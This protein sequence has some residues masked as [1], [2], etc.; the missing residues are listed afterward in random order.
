MPTGITGNSASLRQSFHN[1]RVPPGFRLDFNLPR[2]KASHQPRS[3]SWPTSSPLP[4][5]RSYLRR[6]A[7]LLLNL[8]ILLQ[9]SSFHDISKH[10]LH[11]LWHNIPRAAAF[12]CHSPMPIQERDLACRSELKDVQNFERD[13]YEGK[14]LDAR[15]WMEAPEKR[16]PSPSGTPA[17]AQPPAYRPNVPINPP[18]YKPKDPMPAPKYPGKP[19]KV[20]QPKLPTIHERR[21]PSPSG[22]PAA[23]QPP[24]YRPNV[25]I[26]PPPYK[27]KD[28]MPAPKYP[29]KPSKVVQPKLPTIH[30]RRSPSPSGTPAAA[31]PPAYRPN[32]PINPP[33]YKPKDPMPAPKYPGKPSKVVQPKLPTIHERR[34]PSPSGTPAA[35][36]PP[37]YRPNVP[38]NPPSYKPRDPLPAPRYPGKPSTFVQPLPT[39]PESRNH[40]RAAYYDAA[41][42]WE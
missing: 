15:D 39:I 20:V 17:P 40:R 32:V 10:V 36:Q 33:P 27:P 4:N 28:P 18:P 6:V 21:S 2:K 31:Q 22:T 35:A 30:E 38:V 19:S 16:S 5:D 9:N 25:P 23:A 29:G 42:D 34:S 7:G 12:Q 37:A 11:S 13:W 14:A 1:E 3:A 26:N 24:A 41:Y 8:P